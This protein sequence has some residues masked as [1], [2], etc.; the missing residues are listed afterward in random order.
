VPDATVINGLAGICGQTGDE[1]EVTNRPYR[2]RPNADVTQITLVNK[3]EYPVVL[4][5]SVLMRYYVL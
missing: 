4:A 2:A 3:F 5:D 1:S